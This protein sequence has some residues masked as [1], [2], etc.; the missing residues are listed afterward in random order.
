MTTQP[1]GAGIL[2][3]RRWLRK[4]AAAGAVAALAPA[5]AAQQPKILPAQQRPAPAAPAATDYDR[6]VVAYVYNNVPITRQELGEFL[7]A[8]KGA[9]KVEGIDKVPLVVNRKIIEIEAHRRGVE[10][11]GIEIAA[12]LAES[13]RESGVREDDFFQF[14]RQRF[15]KSRYE[16]EQDVIR[17]RILLGK[18]CKDRVQVTADE[19]RRL[20]DNRY[21]EKRKAQVV[22]F[23]KGKEPAPAVRQAALTSADQFVQLAT[24][25]PNPEFAKS[26][27]VMLPVGR[28]T[29]GAD[30][31][32]EQALFALQVGQTSQWIETAD[33]WLCLKLLEVTPPN[34]DVPLDKVRAQ[35]EKELV[36]KKL[37]EVIPK[38]VEELKKAANPV[39]TQHVPVPPAPPAEPGQPAPPPV[40]APEADPRVLARIYGTLPVT[41]EELG[42][43]LIARGGYEK[44]GLLVN[45]RI[46]EI[47]AQRR[48]VAVTPQEIDAALK[49]DVAGLPP[50][51]D[52]QPVS[53]EEFVKHLLPV[54]GMSLFEYTEDVIRPRLLLRKMCQDRVKVTDDDLKLAFENKFGEKRGAKLI[55]WPKEQLRQA[56]RQ[57]DECRKGDTQQE[58]DVNFD[59]VARDQPTRELAARAGEVLPVGRHNDADNPVVEQVLFTLKEGE[60]SHLVETAAGIMCVKCTKIYPPAGNVTLEV[61]RPGLEK[62]V[63]EKKL[64][65][66]AAAFFGE[67][68]KA[69]NPN[70]LLKGPPTDR[71]NAEGVRQLLHQVES[72]KK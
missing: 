40:R 37:N 51:N 71:E 57:W 47:E 13:V 18:M 34:A 12:V 32:V 70:V 9:D 53:V 1:R 15:D 2:G 69:A 66:E 17:P 7:I 31:V 65:K 67:L 5:A 49:S 33:S 22:A 36:E 19:V 45:R 63:F 56:Q 28:H 52:G 41:R 16:W 35:L 48:G 72:L 60:V 4:L 26:Q 39:L 27:G 29:E 42:E 68:R 25:Q 50:R 64:A 62:D 20:Y 21:G 11:T 10:A 30:P 54:K 8:R 44:L 24:T 3:G 43:F 23:P 59:R 14:I 55:I 46:I 38:F 6:R 61:A 58:R